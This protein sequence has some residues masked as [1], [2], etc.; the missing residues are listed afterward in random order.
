MILS[1]KSRSLCGKLNKD[2]E[3]GKETATAELL[4]QR[5]HATE[6]ERCPVRLYLKFSSHRP[7]EMKRPDAPFFLAINHL[8]KL[9]IRCCAVEPL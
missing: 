1:L 7:E 6:N 5:A 2:R 8:R 3:Q 9:E 4:I